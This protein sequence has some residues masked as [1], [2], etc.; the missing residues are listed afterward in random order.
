MYGFKS[1][2]QIQATV[3]DMGDVKG[4]EERDDRKVREERR[5]D[6]YF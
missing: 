5:G 2:L 4:Q 1:L 6:E 3:F